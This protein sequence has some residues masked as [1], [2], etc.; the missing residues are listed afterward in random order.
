MSVEVV[1]VWAPRP[2]HEKWRDTYLELLRLQSLTAYRFGHTHTIVT[3]QRGAAG[4]PML[5]R[6]MRARLPDDLMQAMIAGVI[7][8]LSYPSESHLLFV[9]ADVLVGRELDSAFEQGLFDLGLTRRLHDRAPINNGSM[10]VDQ[11]GRAAALGFFERALARCGT[12]WG[13]DQEAISEEAAPVPIVDGVIEQREWGRLAFLSMRDYSCV[14]KVRG[15]L[16]V[17]QPYAIHFKGEAKDWAEEYAL[18]FLLKDIHGL[19]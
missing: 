7:A 9:D 1:T 2:G 19:G 4:L 8:R 3:D 13:A 16:H 10:Y 15:Q 18:R 17:A 5:S 11:R 12:H 14:P 6:A